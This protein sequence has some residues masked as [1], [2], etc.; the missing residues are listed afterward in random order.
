MHAAR[1]FEAADFRAGRGVPIDGAGPQA[2]A[3]A[4]VAVDLVHAAVLGGVNLGRGRGA[5][6]VI[7]LVV[8]G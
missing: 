5:L 3:A 1:A 7:S 8:A 4:L 2:L 6:P